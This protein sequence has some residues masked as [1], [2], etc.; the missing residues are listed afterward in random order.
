MQVQRLNMAGMPPPLEGNAEVEISTQ[1]LVVRTFKVWEHKAWL[2]S[3]S[4]AAVL[5]AGLRRRRR[6]SAWRRRGG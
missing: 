3:E 4:T 6:R 5:R 1:V 2:V